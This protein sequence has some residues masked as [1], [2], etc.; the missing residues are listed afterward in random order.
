MTLHVI[1]EN[2]A[3]LP[4]LEASLRRHGVP[5]A[6]QLTDGGVFDLSAP[7]PPGVFLNRMSPSSHTRGNQGG[8]RFLGE[9]LGFLEAHGRRVLNGSEA[10]SLEVSKIRQDQALR[11][12]GIRTPRTIAVVGK[13]RL[14]IGARDMEFPFITKHNQGGKGL[15]VRLF[16]E[17]STFT[18]YVDGSDFVAGPD[19]VTL[20]QQ[21]IEPAQ[22]F[23]TRVEIV[24]GSFQ[25]AIRSST[26]DGFELCPAVECASV[27][28]H[29]PADGIGKFSLREDLTADDPLIRRYLDLMAA[30]RIDIA[31]IEFVEDRDGTRYTYDINGTTNYNQQVEERHGLDGMDAI[32]R[33]A[34]TALAVPAVTAA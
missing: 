23:I 17:L 20:L 4:P 8:V 7:P 32:A 26:E 14:K 22:P 10:F 13:E 27:D 3:W 5:Y 24:G 1:Y 19:D 30:L 29:C 2:Q 31:G 25:Y 28:A 11:A 18:A 15:G 16:H 34:A 12:F 33:M 6:L 21:Y 9:Y